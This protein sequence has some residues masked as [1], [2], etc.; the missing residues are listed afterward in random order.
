[1]N[2]RTRSKRQGVPASNQS[3]Y[4]PSPS[5]DSSI[6]SV[7]STLAQND[8]NEKLDRLT[9]VLATF[10]EQ[11]DTS[12]VK[13]DVIPVFDPDDVTF[14]T[15]R[16]LHQV[17]ELRSVYKWSEERTS[18]FALTRLRGLAKTWYNGL[19]TVKY[20]WAEWKEQLLLAFPS[21]RDFNVQLVTMLNRRKK[22]DESYAQYFYEKRALLNRC[23]IDGLKAVSCI[24]GGIED[25]IVASAARAGRY[26]TPEAL[27]VYLSTVKVP[28]TL[29]HNRRNDESRPSTSNNYADKNHSS[30]YKKGYDKDN[31]KS[32]SYE[33]SENR[34]KRREDG[35]RKRSFERSDKST[36]DVKPIIKWNDRKDKKPRV[37]DE[38]V[39]NYCGRRNH[40]E[41]FCFK[42]KRDA[43]AGGSSSEK[44]A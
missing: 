13:A 43:G 6:P 8:V 7:S 17:D 10:F 44:V 11:K 39:C 3:T 22:S 4:R 16:W 35:A 20:S 15:E 18:Y 25:S 19:S 24:I 37:G 30:S 41:E 27:F 2:S 26:Q 14:T 36:D 12:T 5:D 34:E 32:H 28:K 29:N 33:R 23:E 40:T 21:E 31:R 42:K 1:M 38:R 9:D